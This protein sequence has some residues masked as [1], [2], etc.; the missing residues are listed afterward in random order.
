MFQKSASSNSLPGFRSRSNTSGLAP[1]GSLQQ[2]GI[3]VIYEKMGNCRAPVLRTFAL[4]LCSNPCTLSTAVPSMNADLV[5]RE[6][7]DALSRSSDMAVAVAAIQA[8]TSVI[9]SSE[10]T[11]VMGLEKELKDAAAS[12]QRSGC[13]MNI[14]FQGCTTL[15]SHRNLICRCNPTA[16]SLKAGCE[17]FLR[18]TTRTSALEMDNFELAKKRL[19]E[20]GRHF[21]GMLLEECFSRMGT[22]GDIS[23]PDNVSEEGSGAVTS[24]ITP[25]IHLFRTKLWLAETSKRAR[26]I[27]AEEGQRFIRSGFTILCHGLSRVVLAILRKAAAAVCCFSSGHH[28]T[29]YCGGS[30]RRNI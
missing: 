15:G 29:S 21:A 19:I 12:L 30:R 27:I 28:P 10:A 2:R 23:C 11:T 1:E 14:V 6:F 25:C 26:A 17:L 22:L 9:R 13:M 20:R 24:E 4:V 7:H 16:I 5:V 3:M 18:Y 8:L